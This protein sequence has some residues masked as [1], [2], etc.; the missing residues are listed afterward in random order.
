MCGDINLGDHTGRGIEVD[1]GR[2][3]L[4][5]DLGVVMGAAAA[6]HVVVVAGLDPGSSAPHHK[7]INWSPGVW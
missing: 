2:G 7:A 3:E 6:S 4:A 5:D 1:R